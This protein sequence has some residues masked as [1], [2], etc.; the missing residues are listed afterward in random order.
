MTYTYLSLRNTA[1][2]NHMQLVTDDFLNEKRKSNP[3]VVPM[4]V[5]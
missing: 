3:G 2:L 4:D 1:G 5:L